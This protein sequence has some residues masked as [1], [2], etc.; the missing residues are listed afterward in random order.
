MPRTYEEAGVQRLQLEAKPPNTPL[1]H[2]WFQAKIIS[3]S[4]DAT[5]E[6]NFYDVMVLNDDNTPVRID[7]GAAR[8]VYA[9]VTNATSAVVLDAD[10]IVSIRTTGTFNRN[11]YVTTG[12]GTYDTAVV[13]TGNAVITSGGGSGSFVPWE[14]GTLAD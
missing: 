12:T 2:R 8:P 11:P 13:Q 4:R 1:T 14:N 3:E 6:C 5:A 9:V 7:R 10:T